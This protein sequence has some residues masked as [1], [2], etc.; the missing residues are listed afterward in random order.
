MDQATIAVIVKT[1]ASVDATV[2]LYLVLGFA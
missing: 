2:V 1:L